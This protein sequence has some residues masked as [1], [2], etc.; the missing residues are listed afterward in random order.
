MG[1]ISDE[2]WDPGTGYKMAV[3]VN[4]VA[5]PFLSER[6]GDFNNEPS[7]SFEQYDY[8]CHLGKNGGVFQSTDFRF[9]EYSEVT[10]G[11]GVC[12]FGSR[13]KGFEFLMA[14]CS[15]EDFGD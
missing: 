1:E 11:G 9:G 13:A 5:N 3:R 4:A 12:S 7:D 6:E 8:D 14:V 10:F 2:I 15:S